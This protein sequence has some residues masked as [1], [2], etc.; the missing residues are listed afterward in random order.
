LA[1]TNAT[2]ARQPRH[3]LH[4]RADCLPRK[5]RHSWRRH[6][7]IRQR[8]IALAC[9]ACDPMIVQRPHR[10]LQL[11]ARHEQALRAVVELLARL[12]IDMRVAGQRQVVGAVGT[13]ARKTETLHG[14]GNGIGQRHRILLPAFGDAFG[15]VFEVTLLR[16]DC[17]C[18]GGG[19]ATVDDDRFE[20]VQAQV[21]PEPV[22]AARL[23]HRRALIDA[24]AVGDHD[25]CDQSTILCAPPARR[26]VRTALFL[27]GAIAEKSHQALARQRHV[28]ILQTGEAEVTALHDA[29]GRM[30]IDVAAERRRGPPLGIDGVT[31][32]IVDQ[33]GEPCIA[34]RITRRV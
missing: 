9:T 5:I 6:P 19:I 30:C 26:P 29:A 24:A 2:S 4:L 27:E 10:R 34:V 16:K 21:L 31:V 12:N 1:R 23:T 17:P 22:R 14:F 18:K 28:Y 15:D 13:R 7:D 3:R 25:R 33:R 32:E 11:G 20:A 8:V